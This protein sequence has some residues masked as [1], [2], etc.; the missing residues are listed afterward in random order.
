M[1]YE[2][3]AWA[4]R[5]RSSTTRMQSMEITIHHVNVSHGLSVRQV[6]QH[7]QTRIAASQAFAAGKEKEFDHQETFP[8]RTYYLIYVSSM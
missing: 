1:H 5:P 8:A 6:Q 3:G 2:M 7:Q 4:R